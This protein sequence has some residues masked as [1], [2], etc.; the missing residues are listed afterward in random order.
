[1]IAETEDGPGSIDLAGC[2]QAEKN[3]GLGRDPY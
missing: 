2:S 1:V 3:G